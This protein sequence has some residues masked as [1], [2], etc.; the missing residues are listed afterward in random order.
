M[1]SM[2]DEPSLAPAPPEVE[3]AKRAAE[4]AAPDDAKAA[5]D[6]AEAL[7]SAAAQRSHERGE[8]IMVKIDLRSPAPAAHA[9]TA[10][11]DGDASQDKAANEPPTLADSDDSFTEV[12]APSY[13]SDG[14]G[15][16]GLDAAELGEDARMLSHGGDA[17]L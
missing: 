4:L 13:D 9:P 3:A 16:A 17:D 2:K 15:D 5:R 7:A 1:L 14:D 11:S 12:S 6:V 10:P 8:D